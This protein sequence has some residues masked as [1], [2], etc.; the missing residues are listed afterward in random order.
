[1]SVTDV[2]ALRW[3]ALAVAARREKTIAAGLRAVEVVH[4]VWLPARLERRAWSD[5]IL[6]V[7]APLFPGY[8]LVRLVLTPASRVQLLKVKGVV[9]VLGRQV[10]RADVA[11]AI[12]DAEITSLRRLVDSERALDPSEKL[13]EGTAVIVGAG[14][15]KGVRG[16][17][18]EGLDGQRIAGHLAY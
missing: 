16:V 12:D 8:L 11:P 6:R 4:S 18:E 17:V 1:M 14:P 3:H 15:L 10:G 13:V 9:D 2:V 7:D 5:R